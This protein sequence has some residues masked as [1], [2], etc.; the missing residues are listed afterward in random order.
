MTCHG[1]YDDTFQFDVAIGTSLIQHS[2]SLQ[3]ATPWVGKNGGTLREGFTSAQ[4][5]LH[6]VKAWNWTAPQNGLVRASP[7][8]GADGSIF[9]SSISG[10]LIKFSKEGKELWNMNAGRTLPGNPFLDGQTLYTVRDDCTFIA[11]DARNGHELWR[12]KAGGLHGPD[13]P[14]VLVGDGMVF[15]ACLDAP[16][17]QMFGGATYVVALNARTGKKLWQVRPGKLMYNFM[18]AVVDHSL[19][20]S[21]A[22]GGVQRLH[23]ANGTAL[24]SLPALSDDQMSTGGLTTSR[25]GIAYVTSNKLDL[26]GNKQGV[27]S[28]YFIKDGQ[29]LWRKHLPM[30]ANS[31]AAIGKK[32]SNTNTYF[33]TVALGP[34]P[35]LATDET[36]KGFED[37]EPYNKDTK[38]GRKPGK[39]MTFDAASGEVLWTYDFPDWY[40][41]AAGDTVKHN[42]LPDSFANPS[43]GGDGSVYV[44]GESGV[45]YRLRDSNGDGKI[46]EHDVDTFD[47]KNAFQGAPAL[48]DGIL[49]AAPC[50]GLVVFLEKIKTNG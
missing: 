14:S 17:Q 33:V 24:W 12:Q 5:P 29:L 1:L 28:A 43:I 26:S 45:I 39:V 9:I 15:S 18:A 4:A 23:L 22:F 46:D 11:V 2:L 30:S 6:L 48:S 10:N 8:I 20:F 13:T 47:A 27:L 42:C 7:V 49:A 25:N 36:G 41:V 31:A 16:E 40:G 38:D 35:A 19:L 34:N 3:K 44:A 37:L 32:A 50:S 21:D